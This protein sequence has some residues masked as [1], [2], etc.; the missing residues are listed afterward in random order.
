MSWRTS[1]SVTIDNPKVWPFPPVS[2]TIFSRP[3]KDQSSVYCNG[4]SL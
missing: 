4:A 2:S 3:F 1:P